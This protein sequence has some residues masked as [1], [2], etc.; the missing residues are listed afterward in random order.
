MKLLYFILGAFSTQFV[1]PLLE[2][3][4]SFLLTAL[5]AG[6]AKKNEIINE[7]NIR[8]QKQI[9]EAEGPPPKVIKG[10]G[11]YD[12]AKDDEK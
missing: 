1:I 9:L 12:S 6:K 11:N 7:S 8:L 5:E 10:F 3:L 2:G 4:L